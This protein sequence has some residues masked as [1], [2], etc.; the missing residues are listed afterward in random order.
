MF[1][2][3][4]IHLNR[5]HGDRRAEQSWKKWKTLNEREGQNTKREK[6]KKRTLSQQATLLGVVRAKTHTEPHR[7]V[8]E[9]DSSVVV[10]KVCVCVCD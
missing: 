9:E 8:E 10:V 5:R 3:Q 6:E 4:P 2:R 1:R 7:E